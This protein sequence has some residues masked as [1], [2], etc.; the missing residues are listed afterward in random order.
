MSV[1]PTRP[2]SSIK[3][4]D[5]EYDKSLLELNNFKYKINKTSID[6]D[7]INTI[8]N[9]MKNNV[10]NNFQDDKDEDNDDDFE[11]FDNEIED[12][13]RKTLYSN[14]QVNKMID[15]ISTF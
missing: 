11:N 9:N 12:M 6:E 8:K 10:K 1:A 7:D 14:N 13:L 3:A 4:Y 2:Y 15:E 5:S